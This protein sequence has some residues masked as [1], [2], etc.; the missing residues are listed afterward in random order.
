MDDSSKVLLQVRGLNKSFYKNKAEISV[1]RNMNF[2]VYEGELI[3]IT[4]ASG[5]GKS[6][7][8]HVLGTLEYPSSGEI[9]FG[10]NK[11]SIFQYSEKKLAEFR[12]R[13]LGFGHP[14]RSAQRQAEELLVFVGLKHRLH[15]RPSE[16]SGGEQQRVAITRAVVLRPRLLF[17]DELTGNLDSVNSELVMDLLVQLNQAM[18]VTIVM[19][20]HNEELAHRTRRILVMK[21]GCFMS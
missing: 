19:V 20:T 16:L 12:N 4:G 1:L 5:A 15:H 17:A 3:A 10:T 8:L 6:T 13:M 14:R 11:E 18:G 9:L 7:L 2:N 21:D